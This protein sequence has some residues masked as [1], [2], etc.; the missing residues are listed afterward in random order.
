MPCN[1]V[2]PCHGIPVMPTINKP[3][4]SVSSAVAAMLLSALF[5]TFV[6]AAATM[7]A[8]LPLPRITFPAAILLAGLCTRCFTPRSVGLKWVWISVAVIAASVLLG[9]CAMDFSSDG[10]YYHQHTVALLMDGWNPYR[11]NQLHSGNPLWVN[12][13]AKAIETVAA[14]IGLTSR[15]IESGKAVNIILTAG[16]AS[17]VYAFL[18]SFHPLWGR[19]RR[20]IAAAAIVC[21][22]VVV[23]QMPTFYIDYAK[24]IYLLL[25]IILIC[26]MASSPSVFYRLALGATVIAAIATKFNIFFEEGVWLVLATVWFLIRRNRTTALSLLLTGAVSLVVGLLLTGHPYLSNLLQHG[27]PLYPL[28]GEG[29]KDIMTT[30]TPEIFASS[31]RITN[32][33]RS[34][35]SPAVPTCDARIGGFGALMPLIL[36]CGA[37]IA[38]RLRRSI[39]PAVWYILAACLASCF[40]FGQ[41]WWARYICQLWLIPSILIVEGYSHKSTR[42]LTNLLVALMLATSAIAAVRAA[43]SV[44]MKAAWR[45]AMLH[46]LRNSEATMVNCYP[47]MERYL[48]EQNITVAH[49]DSLPAGFSG[50]ALYYYDS[51]ISS[52]V[53]LVTHSQASEIEATCRRLHIDYGSHLCNP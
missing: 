16:T 26:R 43:G 37:I 50:V 25:T 33:F 20:L 19:R 27:H 41:T 40:F 36:A 29:A 31:G 6:I 9:W 7:T 13:Y 51:R 5:F 52:P 2:A 38:V 18:G 17:A 32:F 11:F 21:N 14:A 15:S 3:L 10:V 24:Y 39:S 42:N 8:G 45:H 4:T 30:N 49:L 44:W 34:L 22:P 46:P 12:C 47:Q 48:G 35:L 1:R 23:A 53:L 28:M